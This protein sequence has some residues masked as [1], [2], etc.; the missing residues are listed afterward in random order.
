MRGRGLSRRSVNYLEYFHGCVGISEAWRGTDRARLRAVRQETVGAVDKQP[1][2]FKDR[3]SKSVNGMAV[4]GTELKG[5]A[6]S[7][8]AVTREALLGKPID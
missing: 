1:L 5:L 3:R 8:K 4:N 6:C 7:G 2:V